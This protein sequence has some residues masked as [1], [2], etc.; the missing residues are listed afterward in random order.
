MIVLI[1]FN[2]YNKSF[3]CIPNFKDLVFVFS[4]PSNIITCVYLSAKGGYL[5]PLIQ[6]FWTVSNE[7][8]FFE[9]KQNNL[10][11]QCA[12]YHRIHHF[13]SLTFKSYRI[14]RNFLQFY[15]LSHYFYQIGEAYYKI[16]SWYYYTWFLHF[17]KPFKTRNLFLWDY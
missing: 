4:Y 7:H 2:I 14:M 6:V 16:H 3:N 15:F 10:H 9:K 8:K 12:Y 13:L 17:F 1:R 5:L 11:N